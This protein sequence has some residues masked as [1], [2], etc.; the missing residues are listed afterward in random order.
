MR[1]EH[2]LFSIRTRLAITTCSLAFAASAGAVTFQDIAR[3]RF[4]ITYERQPSPDNT[5]AEATRQ[6]GTAP[7]LDVLLGPIKE[8]GAPGVALFDWDRDG[9]LDLY[10]TNGPGQP[11]SLYSNQLRERGTV[12]FQDV[13]VAVGADLTAQ[14]SQGVCYGDIDNDGDSDLMV[15]GNGEPNHLLENRRTHFVDITMRAR[16]GGGDLHHFSCVMGDIDG[17]GLLDI[18]V[19]NTFDPV[20]KMAIAVEPFALNE[21]NQLFRNLGSR[22]FENVSASAGINGPTNGI[23]W[24]TT[25]F[26]YDADGDLDIFVA[27]DQGAIPPAKYPGGLDRGRIQLL[28]NDGRGHFTDAT[29][30]AR[31]NKPESNMGFAVADWDG[32]GTLDLAVSNIGDWIEPFLGV[33]YTLGDQT[34]RWFL[35]DG[36]GTFSDPG[37]GPLIASG[38][39]WGIST[40]DVENDGDFDYLGLGGFDLSAFIDETNPGAILVNDGFAHFTP[41]LGALDADHTRRNDHG[42][43]IGDLD[44]NGFEDIVSVSIVNRPES[45]PFIPHT[46]GYDSYLDPFAGW[47]PVW[48]PTG[49]DDLWC[50][51]GVQMEN[52]TL[53]IEMNQGGNGNL[54][55]DVD[56]FGTIGLT[57]DGAVNRD[58]IGAV[59]RFT[60]EG[61]RTASQPILGGS[62]IASQDSL[63]AH[64]GLGRA[65]TGTVE[66]VWPG[67]V[68]NRLYDVAAREKVRF[69]EIP[70]NFAEEQNRGRYNACVR[71]ALK[72]LVR[73]GAIS[74]PE[75]DRL[76]RS[77]L[78]AFDER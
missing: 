38:W 71:G 43:A 31:L 49:T 63:T 7:F 16:V 50:W 48:E 64:F 42:V 53:A 21:P 18:F 70:C 19:T 45:F 65:R 66:V 4:G 1:F 14:D 27:D 74:K 37:V 41:L 69:P 44:G 13:A 34:Q 47:A 10:V 52:G 68:R 60:P 61:G 59:V 32:N 9:D 12:R 6:R 36:D 51:N 25:M 28:E 30:A 77:A 57:D 75:R 54:W 78:R 20:S 56:V 24:A 8:R 39:S 11:N 33:P 3:P 15:L 23:S 55:V 72:D 73:Q 17:D 29:V 26:D 62:S 58:G 46:F 5:I 35:N 76:L 22:R 40:L 67:G 2:R